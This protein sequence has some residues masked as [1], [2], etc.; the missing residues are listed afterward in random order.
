MTLLRRVMATA[1]QF[2]A[3]RNFESFT[4]VA[5]YAVAI[6]FGISVFNLAEYEDIK[7]REVLDTYARSTTGETLGALA[8]ARLGML[9]N[10][11]RLH[12]RKTTPWTIALA[13]VATGIFLSTVSLVLHTDGHD[14]R[15][16]PGEPTPAASAQLH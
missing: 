9:E 12:Q 6:G 2:L 1:T 5:A 3:A 8:G 16:E 14:K 4:G 11:A 10:N 13:A 7:P 15:T